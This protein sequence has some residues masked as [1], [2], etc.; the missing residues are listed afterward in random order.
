ML[1]E[2]WPLL[3]VSA[4]TG[5][6]LDPLK[7]TLFERLEIIRVYSKIPGKKADLTAPFIL[8]KGGTIEDFAGKVHHDF[9][10]NLKLARIWG[11]GVYDGQMVQRDHV[12]HDKDVVELHM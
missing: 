11:E 4:T 7:Q 2:D 1:E 10:D 9:V 8:K 6:N 5:R 3:P 12:L